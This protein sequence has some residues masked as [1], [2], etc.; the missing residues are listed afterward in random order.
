MEEKDGVVVVTQIISFLIAGF[1]VGASVVVSNESVRLPIY[2]LVVASLVI[3][4][5]LF[6]TAFVLTYVRDEITSTGAAS[7]DT[8]LFGYSVLKLAVYLSMIAV[9][10][11]VILIEAALIFLTFDF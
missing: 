6:A 9:F 1:G 3:L 2:A 8:N 10:G 7:S 5:L 11:T 4:S